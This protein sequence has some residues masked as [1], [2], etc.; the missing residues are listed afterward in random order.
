M[1]RD[2]P[3]GEIG[4]PTRVVV[5]G[6]GFAGFTALR[7][8]ERLLAR[9]GAEGDI[10]LVLV[11][12]QDYMLYTPLLPEVAS[13]VLQPRSVAVPLRPTLPGTTVVPGWATAVDVA[14][15]TVT[16][17]PGDADGHVVHVPWDRLVL[18]PG[19]VTRQF[20]VP[21]VE[22]V[23]HGVKTVNEALF[24]RDHLLAQLDRADALPDTAEG[25]A[26]REG[27]L[28]VVAVGA[29]YTSTELVGQL[30]RWL[31]AIA[32]RWE[33]IRPADVRWLLLD[34]SHTVLPELGPVL[35]AVATQVLRRRGVDVRLGT[36][37]ASATD[38]A[39]VLTDGTTVPT[40]TLIW[41]AGVVA[42][43]LVATVGA[44]T[45]RGRLVV[46]AQLRVDGLDHV[47]AAGDAAAV[48]DLTKDDG[49]VMPPTAQH[50]Q[51]QGV[52]LADNV[53]ASLGLGHPR[54]YAH[55][56]LGLVADLG[57]RDAVANPLGIP[58][59]GLPAKVVTRGYHLLAVPGAGNRVRLAVDWALGA[60]LAPHT[61]RLAGVR[62]DD[63]LIPAA[64]H[65]AIY[66]TAGSS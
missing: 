16:V 35:G 10:E 66:D 48:P 33:R 51:R 20:A 9:R 7:R 57:G 28:T 38:R 46:D 50:A 52:V 63:A 44:P 24:L 59:T 18:V 11:S 14:G 45:V 30:Q 29:G 31:H 42:S 53:A 15:R 13:G 27:R 34:V 1:D 39:V 36:T 3:T 47:W 41:G 8:L 19:S 12:P 37:V 22:A 62:P 65:T 21:G 2:R 25:R 17:D 64:Q 5:V 61:V 40:R 56:D 55:R 49:A 26:E 60:L 32:S 4:A 6:A 43:P 58:L 23:A 54:R